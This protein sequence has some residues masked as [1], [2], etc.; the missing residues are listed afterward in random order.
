MEL[1]LPARVYVVGEV[2]TTDRYASSTN[3]TPYAFGLQWRAGGIN[4]SA[5]LTI[6]NLGGFKHPSFFFG[7][8][9]QLKF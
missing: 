9:P 1:Q 8:G 6:P 4:L 3:T 2:S 7:I 5:G